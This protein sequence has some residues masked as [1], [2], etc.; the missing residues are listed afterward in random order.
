ML[1]LPLRLTSEAAAREKL[2][3]CF[4]LPTED[5]ERACL[6][7][8]EDGLVAV[9]L[10]S[11]IGDS[12]LAGILKC[13]IKCLPITR[14]RM[15]DAVWVEAG[16]SDL[17]CCGGAKPHPGCAVPQRIVEAIN[18]Y[19]SR[20]VLEPSIRGFLS[21]LEKQFPRNDL[22]VFE[23][24]QNAVDD[25]A[26]TVCFSLTSTGLRFT[27]DGR[28]FS[29]LDV[30]GLASVGLS[31]KGADGGARRT[32][33]FMGIGYKA[34][35][36]RFSRV[37]VSDA[38]FTFA[39]EE[40]GS[41]DPR[42]PGHSWVMLPRWQHPI[43]DDADARRGWCRFSLEQPRVDRR[44]L[45]QDLGS[46]PRSVAPLLGRQSLEN[47]SARPPTSSAPPDAW[48]LEWHDVAHRVTRPSAKASLGAENKGQRT[49]WL[50]E[51]DLIEVASTSLTRPSG[52]L[53]PRA[54][55]CNWQ[56]VVVKFLPDD[57][58]QAAF[59]G[60]VKRKWHGSGGFEETS[61][62]FEVDSDFKPIVSGAG[63]IHS[64]LPTKLA[65][66]W[67]VTIFLLL[68]FISTEH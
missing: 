56:F 44:V 20:Q 30:L 35:Y 64:V 60:H 61:I 17:V 22:Y 1:R 57:A 41:T 16:S 55:R 40:P 27:H 15:P 31:T 42:I 29:A 62:F 54:K 11:D 67:C 13:D 24:L 2:G 45:E 68:C 34:V 32:I 7:V 51:S 63:A 5:E 52:G 47:F 3:H 65:L 46:L 66:P 6:I 49:A 39:F 36:R 4:V 8:N 33:G 43:S 59:E 25:G 38:N 14:L 21:I 58:A 28:P 23:L 9:A 50:L 18:R 12:D 53:A 37:V 48:T 19:Y 10:N 26:T